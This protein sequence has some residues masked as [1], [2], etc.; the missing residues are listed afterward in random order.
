MDN[1]YDTIAKSYNEL[2]WNEQLNKLKV[3]NNYLVSKNAVI[4]STTKI[5]DVGCG[6]GIVQD[7]FERKYHADTFGIDPSEGLI[8]Q[9][10]YQCM[11]SDAEDMPFS[12][13][14]FDIVISLTALQN[15]DDLDHGLMEMKRVGKDFFIITFLKRSNKAELMEKL[16]KKYYTV[17]EKIEEDKDLIFICGLV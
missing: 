5:L 14:E 6:T 3:I 12:D 9:N 13:G 2:H 8:K 4:D 17:K 16:I 1:Y 11:L 15:F 10:Q 7:F